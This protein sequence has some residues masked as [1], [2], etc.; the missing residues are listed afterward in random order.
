MNQRVL[1]AGATGHLGRALG[2]ALKEAGYLVRAL[3]RHSEQLQLVA[4]WAAETVV[5]QAT[6]P[7]Q[8]AGVAADVDVVIS[9]VGITLQNDGATYEEV[10]FG[11]NRNLLDETLRQGVDHFAYVASLGGESM[12]HM[13][14]TAAKE[15]FVDLLRAAP[16]RH[17]VLR[18]NA[19]FHDFEALL[20][21]A[22][23]GRI[24]LVGEGRNRLNPVSERDGA[25]RIVTALSATDDNVDFGGPQV[26]SWREIAEA[27]FR[28]LNRA[29]AITVLDPAKV[30]ATVEM[31]PWITP[32]AVHGPLSFH[33]T[34][35]GQD[36]IGPRCGNDRLI[37]WLEA[38]AATPNRGRPRE[39]AA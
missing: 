22:M 28:L 35:M 11:A 38:R 3:V 6:N 8:L 24:A 31:L 33:L 20:G 16:I 26:L 34:M 10:D 23:A 21:Q 32:E 18:P 25:Q 7:R 39:E 19:L 37:D 29:R 27:C 5:A 2:P 13:P 4:P 12:R 14:M 15:R 36:S 17:T 30:A 9:A 1:L